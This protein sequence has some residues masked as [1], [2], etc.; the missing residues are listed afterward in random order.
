MV[1]AR[2]KCS[3]IAYICESVGMAENEFLSE[4]DLAALA[5]RFRKQAG[6]SRAQAARDIQVAQPSI[7]NAEE[8]P[9]QSLLKLRIRIIETYSPYRVV[10][11]VFLL[12]KK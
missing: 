3:Q 6:V 10:G 7:F 1:I 4:K 8:T 11:P 12:K 5:K 9:T 2:K